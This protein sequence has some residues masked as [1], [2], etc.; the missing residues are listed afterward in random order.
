MKSPLDPPELK[1]QLVSLLLKQLQ[2]DL[3]ALMLTAH[4]AKDA[5]TTEESKAENKYDTRGLEASYLAGAQAKRADEFKVVLHKLSQLD[6]RNFKS[7]DPISLTALVQVRINEETEKNFFILPGAGGT[8][9]SLHSSDYHIITT[10]SVVGQSLVGK[11]VGDTFEIKINNK[12]FDY[13]ITALY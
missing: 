10:D 9:L 3:D 4:I 11:R 5:A 13:Q 7:G 6:P 2:A 8:K 12:L 1:R